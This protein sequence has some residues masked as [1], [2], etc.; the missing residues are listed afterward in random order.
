MA[1]LP[2][3]E[4]GGA[5]P[6]NNKLVIQVAVG[7]VPLRAQAK[8]IFFVVG[9]GWWFVDT[10]MSRCAVIGLAVVLQGCSR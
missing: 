2:A 7:N 1:K 10:F 3:G 9:Q 5:L 8:E 6:K 4:V